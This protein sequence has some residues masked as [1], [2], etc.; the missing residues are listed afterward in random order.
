MVR[1][2]RLSLLGNDPEAVDLDAVGG[3]VV[4]LATPFESVM[5]TMSPGRMS[6]LTVSK[7]APPGWL[8]PSSGLA[9][10]ALPTFTPLRST[11]M[12][13]VPVVKAG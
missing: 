8:M 7:Q 1:E 10:T 11:S 6:G 5:R 9:V 12:V 2:D 4:W 13:Y 3:V